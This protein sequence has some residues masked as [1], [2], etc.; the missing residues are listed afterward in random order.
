MMSRMNPLTLPP[1]LLLRA[2]GDLHQ[3][4]SA[5]RSIAGVLEDGTRD[6]EVAQ[7]LDDLHGLRVAAD[8]I[9]AVEAA[10][11]ERLDALHQRGGDMLE[12]GQRFEG[13]FGSVLEAADRLD[14]RAEGVLEAFEK[15]Q[16]RA[17]D[18]LDMG[19]RLDDRAAEI[20]EAFAS[21]EERGDALLALATRI[22]EGTP[23]LNRA[24]EAIE[25]LNEAAGTLASTAQPMQGALER[26]GR[27]AD[28]LP[29][30]PRP[31]RTG[32]GPP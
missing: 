21:F 28:R 23:E 17:Q 13:L 18:I 1:R 8:R 15:V 25:T 9:P 2:L 12:L 16:V 19:E 4:A 31:P 26:V 3:L 11:T 5:A 10:M 24:L 22:E 20:L 32:T 27:I 7:T 6:R 29:G 14:A 30:S